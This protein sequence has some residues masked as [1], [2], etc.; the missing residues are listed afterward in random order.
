MLIDADGRE[1]VSVHRGDGLG[2]AALRRSGLAM[3]VL[4]T[5]QNPVVAAG[6]G[7]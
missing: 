2:I 6:P 1:F 7:S 4:S 3:L 5:E